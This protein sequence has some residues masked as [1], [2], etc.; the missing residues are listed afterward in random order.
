M[1]AAMAWSRR[2]VVV[3]VVLA[4][5]A[6]ALPVAAQDVFVFVLVAAGLLA[7]LPHGSIDH[8]LAAQLTGRSTLL[9]GLG[10]AAVAA[11]TWVLLTTTGPIALVPVLGLS[12]VHF[13]LG[14]LEV[15]RSTTTWRPSWVV[16]A[17]VSL[18]GTGALLLPLARAGG[19]LSAVAASISPQLGALIASTPGR[20]GLVALWTSAA[21]IAMVAA[22]R[23]RQRS[24]VLDVV[25]IGALGALAPPLVAFALWF[26][27][28]HALRHCARLLCVDGRSADLISRGETRR[29]IAV[30]ARV[31]AGPTLAA[32]LVLAGLVFFTATSADPS[33]AVGST[34]VVLLALTVPHVLV[35]V[36]MD[37]RLA[38][39]SPVERTPPR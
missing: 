10:Y 6:R 1:A 31:A 9:V 3:T 17:A 29:A 39:R 25:L 22:T 21:A 37:R 11:V 38:G 8:R 7:G 20:V 35:V 15:L 13:A 19:Q 16:S 33:A 28:W 18:A 12:L 14:E 2:L 36:G 4:L 32:V 26:G 5:G 27:G 24:V 34:L 23:A 30:L